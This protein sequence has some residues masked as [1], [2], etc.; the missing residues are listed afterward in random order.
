MDQ[1]L[2]LLGSLLVLLIMFFLLRWIF[3]VDHLHSQN[4]AIIRLLGDLAEKQGVEKERVDK[5]IKTY[6]YKD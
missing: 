3:R 5:I 1:T 2:I 6:D 4:K